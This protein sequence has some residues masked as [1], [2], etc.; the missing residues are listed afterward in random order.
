MNLLRYRDL[1]AL[2]FSEPQI[3]AL[4]SQINVTDG[5][6]DEGKM[7][8]RNGRPSDSFPAPFE[9]EKAARFVNNGA[10]P[11]DLSLI[12]KARKHGSDYIFLCLLDMKRN[13]KI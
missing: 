8:K 3:K 9:N 1:E 2:G 12:V 5:P 10:Y 6:N 11:P 13:Q 7:I 4:A